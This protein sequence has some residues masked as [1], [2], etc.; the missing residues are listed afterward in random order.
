MTVFKFATIDSLTEK[1]AAW[2]ASNL[3]QLEVGDFNPIQTYPTDGGFD[4]RSSN[5][6]PIIFTPF[7]YKKIPLGIKTLIPSN[8]YLDIRPRSSTFI[9]RK[10]HPLV[11]LIDEGFEHELQ[12][13]AQFIPV[14]GVL[15]ASC[16]VNFGDR[17]A[18]LVPHKRLDC[19]FSFLHEKEITAEYSM[20]VNLRDGGFGS[21]D[22]VMR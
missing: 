9:N 18:Q 1:V 20:R 17:I 14:Q 22:K 15:N 2:N 16:V 13:V 19:E 5:L 10:L 12:F 8:H 4:V 3:V 11:G 7:E 21:S 6:E